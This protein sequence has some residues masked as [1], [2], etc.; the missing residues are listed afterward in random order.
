MG[1][2]E[3]GRDA[4]LDPF[5]KESFMSYL[6]TNALVDGNIPAGQS[7]P[8]A[9]E[10][11]LIMERCPTE[12]N[13]KTVAFSC[14]LARLNSLIKKENLPEDSLLVKVRNGL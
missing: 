14:A 11:K 9:G 5:T 10:C 1:Q 8:F 4:D 6:N 12:D 7:C 13:L 3:V 2:V